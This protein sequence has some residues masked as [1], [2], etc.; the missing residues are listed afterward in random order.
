MLFI[1]GC[2]NNSIPAGT[3]YH[4]ETVIDNSGFVKQINESLT[5]YDDNTFL[6]K[7]LK[8]DVSSSGVIN[9]HGDEYTF[10]GPFGSLTGKIQ[11]GNIVTD[12]GF[13]FT[14]QR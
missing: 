5:I 7:D 6:F 1:S 4:N 3:Y 11:N 10:I 13:N 2:L 8:N 14:K 9:R 12:H